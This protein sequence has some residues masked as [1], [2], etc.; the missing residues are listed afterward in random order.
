MVLE[1]FTTGKIASVVVLS[2]A[3]A[4]SD[5]MLP[6]AWAVCLDVGRKHA[7]AVTGP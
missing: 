6:V 5:F 3:Y 2:M 4:G 7:G 1:M